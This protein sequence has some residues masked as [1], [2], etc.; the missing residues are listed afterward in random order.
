[1]RPGPAVLGEG[2]L[3]CRCWAP[4]QFCS[5]R[6][7]S[8]GR[9][10]AEGATSSG[11]RRGSAQGAAVC[12]RANTLPGS[13]R[14]KGRCGLCCWTWTRWR[15]RTKGNT[16]YGPSTYASRTLSLSPAFLAP[17]SLT[18]LGLVCQEGPLPTS[19]LPVLPGP[20]QTLSPEM[21]R[22]YLVSR[23]PPRHLRWT[24]PQSKG[25]KPG[26]KCKETPRETTGR[27]GQA[28]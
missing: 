7:R 4:R 3:Y 21:D 26:E 10:G 18:A 13:V 28:R 11:G 20:V 6:C 17:P 8:P 22:C 23:S 2:R 14:C 12:S 25:Q 27:D 9:V 24:E 19:S 1:M 16:R 15:W 5:G